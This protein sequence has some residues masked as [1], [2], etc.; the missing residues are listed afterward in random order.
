MFALL[1][2]LT[3]AFLLFFSINLSFS[4]PEAHTVVA[5][6]VHIGDPTDGQLQVLQATRHD[7]LQ[8]PL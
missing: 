4:L 5:G 6:D 2:F 7:L 8:V 3:V 1:R